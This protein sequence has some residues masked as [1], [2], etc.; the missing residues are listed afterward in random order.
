MNWHTTNTK[1]Y[2]QWKQ[3]ANREG[4]MFWHHACAEI[5]KRKDMTWHQTNTEKYEQRLRDEFDPSSGERRLQAQGATHTATLPWGGY[6]AFNT[7]PRC[8]ECKGKGRIDHY[9]Q[10]F[11]SQPIYSQICPKCNGYKCEFTPEVMQWINDDGSLRRY[12]KQTTTARMD[13][14]SVNA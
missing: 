1:K 5:G 6:K 4:R 9:A 2:G 13:A 12:A 3:Q 7:A 14:G 8:T 10:E 11:S